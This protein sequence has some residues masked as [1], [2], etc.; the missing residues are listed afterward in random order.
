[1]GNHGRDRHKSKELISFQRLKKR[2][3]LAHH[4]PPHHLTLC[5]MAPTPW[6]TSTEA[7]FL[8]LQMPD[9]IQ[10]QAEG[11]LHLFWG[12]MFEER[13][14]LQLPSAEAMDSIPARA[15]TPEERSKLATAIEMRKKQ[16]ATWFRYQRK[17]IQE[18]VGADAANVENETSLTSALF[19]K[20]T[21]TRVHQAIE[22]FQKRQPELI[23][24]RL[25]LVRYNLVGM[26][27]LPD[28]NTCGPEQT[29]QVAENAVAN[30]DNCGIVGQGVTGGVR[31]VQGDGREGESRAAGRGNGEQAEGEDAR[32]ETEE[33][34]EL[35]P[36]LG[37]VL[38]V[39]QRETGWVGMTILGGPHPRIGGK[40]SVKI[41]CTGETPAGNNFQFSFP[42]FNEVRTTFALKNEAVVAEDMNMHAPDPGNDDDTPPAWQPESQAAAKP[43]NKTK[44]KLKK[45]ASS[46]PT[47]APGPALTPPALTPAAVPASVPVS[48]AE[49]FHTEPDSASMA[50]DPFNDDRAF[51]RAPSDEAAPVDLGNWTWEQF[52]GVLP[53]LS[54]SISAGSTGEDWL[55]PALPLQRT[56]R[57]HLP[58]RPHNEDSH[59]GDED[60]HLIWVPSSVMSPSPLLPTPTS[61]FTS[62]A[63][64]ASTEMPLS[65]PLLL[66][67]TPPSA[68]TFSAFSM[69]PSSLSPLSATSPVGSAPADASSTP[70]GAVPALSSFSNDNPAARPCARPSFVGQNT[71]LFKAFQKNPLHSQQQPNPPPATPFTFLQPKAMSF[72]FAPVGS[73]SF[74][75]AA[76]RLLPTPLSS[77]PPSHLPSGGSTLTTTPTKAAEL[78]TRFL[79]QQHSGVSGSLP[80]VASAAPASTLATAPPAATALST[81]AP[82]APTPSMPKSRPVAKQ[83]GIPAPRKVPAKRGGQKKVAT[84]A[85]AA[86]GGVAMTSAAN[87]VST[88][89]P[90]APVMVY[91]AANNTCNFNKRADA[92]MATRQAKVRA[93]N[94]WLFNPSGPSPLFIVPLPEGEKQSRTQ[95]AQLLVDGPRAVRQ[96]KYTRAELRAEREKEIGERL[97]ASLGTK[98]RA[99]ENEVRRRGRRRGTKLIGPLEEADSGVPQ[100]GPPACCC[101]TSQR[102]LNLLDSNIY[103]IASYF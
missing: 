12:P 76:R 83:P 65:S 11:K 25:E 82:S 15:L 58:P 62:P 51:P 70:T 41:L 7:A 27:S 48:T 10:Q 78:L 103:I 68:P 52:T 46:G 101:S 77:Q 94:A 20:E 40:L 26:E 29:E 13:A 63:L 96:K 81:P 24:K 49:T 85:M 102:F 86:R 91:N 79:S 100:R 37:K 6:A 47:P 61:I 42:K 21:R 38:N 22:C 60:H 90:M 45:M 73:F 98:K 92:A 67:T 75:S 89:E 99:A 57:L 53:A 59:M 69:P 64:S 55:P 43:R 14:K 50:N 18:G 3:L 4:V 19:G 36:M 88:A 56:P 87:A 5:T 72:S 17:K 32:V 39:A 23:R 93:D 35:G 34:D 84:S 66:S 16:I 1:M 9:Y 71:E 97:L 80:T 44:R 30:A 33:I 31:K 74:A 2:Q 54:P 95:N 8:H 28:A